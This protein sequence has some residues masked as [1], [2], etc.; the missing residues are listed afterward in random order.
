MRFPIDTSRLQFMVV[1][2]AEELR[3]REAACG[4]CAE[5]YRGDAYHLIVAGLRGG[6]GIPNR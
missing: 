6:K 3:R 1:A 2:A 5:R 4:P